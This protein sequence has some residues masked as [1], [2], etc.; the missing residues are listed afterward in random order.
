MPP[1]HSTHTERIA[2]G[3]RVLLHAGADGTTM[4]QVMGTVARPYVHDPR[5]IELVRVDLAQQGLHV[6][7][8]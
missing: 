3:G 6:E 4:I 1:L 5:P 7:I 2:T 8:A